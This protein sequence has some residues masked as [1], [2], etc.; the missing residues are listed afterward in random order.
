MCAE[1]GGLVRIA[2]FQWASGARPGQRGDLGVARLDTGA[3]LDRHD[4]AQ[5]AFSQL[6]AELGLQT[7]PM[8]VRAQQDNAYKIASWLAGRDELARVYY[9]G[10]PECDPQNLLGRQLS[11]PG[12]VLSF[13]VHGGAQAAAR[14]AGL[15]GRSGTRCP[16]AAWTR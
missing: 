5:T 10:L 4:V 15:S 8:R 6:A 1:V 12:A 2:G 14:V 13:A 7:L 9:P 16:W 3:C 11:G